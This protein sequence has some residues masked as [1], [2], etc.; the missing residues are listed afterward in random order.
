RVATRSCAARGAP[1]LPQVPGGKP[2]RL[3]AAA[4]PAKAPGKVAKTAAAPTP[5]PAAAAPALQLSK[6]E[7]R[8]QGETLECA[9]ATL[10]A[11]SREINR[12]AKAA[13]ARIA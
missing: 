5:A 2:G 8:V 10:R 4:V 12:T 11:K 9:N 3:T 6:C 1:L 13:A 7:L